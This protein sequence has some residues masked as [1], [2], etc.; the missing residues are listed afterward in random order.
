MSVDRDAALA[1]G[2]HRLVIDVLAW[3]DDYPDDQVD[4]NAVA[5]LRQSIDWVLRRLP[6]QQ[7]DRLAAGDPDPASLKAA[8]GLVVDLMWWLDTCEEDE[9]DSHV[10]VKL[11]ESGGVHLDELPPEQRERLLEVL[12]E[13]AAEEPHAGRRYELRCFPFWM[14]LVEEEPDDEAPA[15][16]EWVRPEARGG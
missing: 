5:T 15:V 16:R 9:V 11:Q 3:L 14:G 10:A 12:R 13:L 2:L 1:H 8:I 4:P 7:R 6:A